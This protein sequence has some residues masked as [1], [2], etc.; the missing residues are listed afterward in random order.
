MGLISKLLPE[1]G[2]VCQSWNPAPLSK[3]DKCPTSHHLGNGV[4]GSAD[5]GAALRGP[6]DTFSEKISRAI[7]IFYFGSRNLND[8]MEQYYFLYYL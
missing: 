8:K 5:I 3:E 4:S 1:P 2:L 7:N 6:R